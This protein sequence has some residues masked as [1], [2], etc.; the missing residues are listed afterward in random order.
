MR[1]WGTVVT[2][3]AV[4]AAYWP[5][6]LSA[7]FVPRWA[8][9]AILVPLLF[10]PDW[11]RLPPGVAAGLFCFLGCAGL[12][13]FLSPDRLTGLYDYILLLVLALAFMA[14]AHLERLDG[15]MTG[16]AIGLVPSTVVVVM[17]MYGWR[18]V[19]MAGTLPS[20]LFFNS[21]VMAEFAALMLV[22]AIA[23]REWW[24]VAVALVPVL[25]CQSRIA[26][27]SVLCG[28]LYLAWRPDRRLIMAVFG[29]LLVAGAIFAVVMLGQYKLGTAAHRIVLWG[30]TVMSLAPLG[31]GLGWAQVAFPI[32]R[33][34]HS[35]LLQMLAEIG[36][37]V[38]LV[39]FVPWLAF[40]GER[41]DVA[42]RAVLVAVGIQAAVS[43]PLHFPAS[44]FVA[45]CVAGYLLGTGRLVRVGQ[46]DGGTENGGR[47]CGPDAAH[48]L[49]YA[50]IAGGGGT[51]SAGSPSAR[52][53]GLRAFLHPARGG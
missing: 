46:P 28:L 6:L 16:L 17:Q 49:A 51:V 37:A 52:G 24:I 9:I 48:R 44:G 15:L 42:E 25:A 34:V 26:V 8:L 36:P 33:F 39:L 43:F 4:S 45:A 5:G 18:G 38:I 21:E 11:R 20:G 35:D 13:I 32:E 53:A 40:R 7:V 29:L 23:R 27:L 1:P 10:T 50:G 30:A 3:F 47:I 12:S 31:N 22:W 19:P 14:A 2:G 41:R